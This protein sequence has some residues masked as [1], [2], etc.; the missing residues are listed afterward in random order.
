M[1]KNLVEWKSATLER[2][3]RTKAIFAAVTDYRRA[4]FEA[5]WTARGLGAAVNDHFNGVLGILFRNPNQH[6]SFW[7]REHSP[8][9]G[10]CPH[11]TPHEAEVF[12]GLQKN[13]WGPQVR[14][15]Q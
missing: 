12:C 11:L 7:T 1:E 14:L 15:E 4:N 5:G 10:E 3:R 2:T 9:L 13:Y 8:Y 6:R